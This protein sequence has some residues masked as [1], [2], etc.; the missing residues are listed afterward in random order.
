MPN[1]FFGCSTI[2]GRKLSVVVYCAHTASQ[3]VVCIISY[4]IGSTNK[5]ECFL[6]FWFTIH[7]NCYC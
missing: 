3:L 5:N 2:M 7:F 1:I 4:L 6:Y